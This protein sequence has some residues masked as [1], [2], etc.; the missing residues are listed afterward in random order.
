MSAAEQRLAVAVYTSSCRC[1]HAVGVGSPRS[2]P[3]GVCRTRP[4]R[5]DVDTHQLQLGVL[6]SAPVNAPDPPRIGRRDLGHR[7]AGARSVDPATGEPRP[8]LSRTRRGRSCARPRRQHAATLVHFGPQRAS[9][10]P[11]RAPPG[12]EDDDVRP[13]ARC[14]R[15]S[16]AHRAGL[17]D[18]ARPASAAGVHRDALHV[19][20]CGAR[21][22]TGSSICSGM[23]RG[24]LDDVS[25]EP[26]RARGLSAARPTGR[27][28]TTT[29]HR[30]VVSVFRGCGRGP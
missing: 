5:R 2:A 18:V 6:V 26:R 19:G 3:S 10:G 17:V 24:P 28:P 9:S 23:R 1:R 8:R 25:L 15:R 20:C 4:D 14:R 29:P 27:P 7:V 21:C 13:R 16:D 22:I 30:L 12:G 11:A